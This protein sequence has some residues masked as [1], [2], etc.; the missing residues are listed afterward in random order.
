VYLT[1]TYIKETK[2]FFYTL[3]TFSIL[4]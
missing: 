2:S 4:L 1:A 3:C